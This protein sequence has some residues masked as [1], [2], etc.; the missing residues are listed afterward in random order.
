MRKVLTAVVTLSILLTCCAGGGI[1]NTASAGSQG[2]PGPQGPAGPQ[3]PQGMQG[4]PGPISPPPS[5]YTTSFPLISPPTGWVSPAYGATL[6][7]P[8]GSYIV[9]AALSEAF[10]VPNPCLQSMG[11]GLP[12]G[13]GTQ[14]WS[15]AAPGGQAAAVYDGGMMVS[16]TNPI[17]V[18]FWVLGL[19]PAD[20]T[21]TGTMYAVAVDTPIQQ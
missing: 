8:A 4:P 20:G 17:T 19:T 10:K 12:L 5:Y 3:G 7:L 21:P 18:N 14:L 11:Q 1:G 13:C 6:N 2:P 16:S 9:H 15:A